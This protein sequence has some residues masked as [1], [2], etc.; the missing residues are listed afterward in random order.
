MSHDKSPPDGTTDVPLEADEMLVQRYLDGHLNDQEL[1][2]FEL[3]LDDEPALQ[4]RLEQADAL[5]AAL[6]SS[7][8]ARS[9]LMWS[10]DLPEGIVERAIE[11]WQSERSP[12]PPVDSELPDFAG[13][14]QPARVL[15]IA[16]VFLVLA[17]GGIAVQQGPAELVKTW[18]LSAKDLLFFIAAHAPSAEQLA[19]GIPTVLL[20]CVAGLFSLSI[21]ARRILRRGR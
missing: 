21:F 2:A 10:D 20:A 6:A 16:N 8:L 18:V 19:Y 15:A 5:F 4:R 14:L 3:R 9:A 12:Q 17:L 13:W 11:R 1:N 7:A